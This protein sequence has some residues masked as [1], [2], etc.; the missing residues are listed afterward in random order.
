LMDVIPLDAS[1]VKGSHGRITDLPDDGPL[2]ISDRA[3][4]LGGR[5]VS[6]LDVKSLLLEAI[7]A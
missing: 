6:A 7:F 1:L 2:I 5:T 3:D 4:L